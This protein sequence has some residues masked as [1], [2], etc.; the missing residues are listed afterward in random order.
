MIAATDFVDQSFQDRR[1]RECALS[2]RD[3]MELK[4]AEMIAADNDVSLRAIAR[5]LGSTLSAVKNRLRVMG[6]EKIV[7]KRNTRRAINVVVRKNFENPL[8]LDSSI[9]PNGSNTFHEVIQLNTL[10]PSTMLMM[11]EDY[12]AER[13]YRDWRSDREMPMSN[14]GMLEI[15][16]ATLGH[17]L[18]GAHER[19]KVEAR[20][21][22]S[23]IGSSKSSSASSN[24]KTD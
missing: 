23:V 8:R 14:E 21:R 1:D 4:I 22:N 7:A 2:R 18:A 19:R 20:A 5:G 3:I 11:K 15:R 17:G 9:L 6:Y 10:D 24:P 13:P 16:A 12:E